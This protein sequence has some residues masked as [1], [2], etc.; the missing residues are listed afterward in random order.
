[1][2]KTETIVRVGVLIVTLAN[3][4]LAFIGKTELDISENT[5]YT[6]ATLITTV[7][8]SMW[9]AWKNNS[10]TKEAKEADEYMKELKNNK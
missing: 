1:M 10:F 7:G 5:L 2:P 4:V 8:A 3:A 9:A 6:V